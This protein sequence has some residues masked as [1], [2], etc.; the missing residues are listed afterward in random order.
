M[1]R[2]AIILFFT[3]L[4]V[5]GGEF[6]E[7]VAK[8]SHFAHQVNFPT[9]P[10]RIAA[11]GKEDIAE[12][13]KAVRLIM[14]PKTKAL[15]EDFIAHKKAHGSCIEKAIYQEMNVDGCIA[16]LI[17][18]RPLAF[19]T[20]EDHYLLRDGK[21]EG[22]GG[23]EAIG[24]DD[25]TY[26]LILRDYISYDEMQLGALIGI[27]VPT[28]FINDGDRYNRAVPGKAG[29][30]EP[31]GI[32]TALVGA[33][34]EKPGLMEWQHM[35]V[36]KDSAATSPLLHLWE[37]F[38]GYTFATYQEAEDD[39][40]GRFIPFKH[41]FFDSAVYKK[42]LQYVIEPFLQDAN[43][44]A[45]TANKKAYVR[46][47]GIG[48][49]VWKIIDKQTDLMLQVYKELLENNSFSHISDID[50]S[51]FKA[52]LPQENINGIALHFTQHNP[53]R[54][55]E[56]ND[57]GKL[58]VACYAWDSNAYP[59]NEYWLSDI[60]ASGDPA[61]ACCSTITELQNPLINRFI[62]SESGA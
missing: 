5:W 48:L 31:Q 54:I 57:A 32:Y 18:K 33:R 22:S 6:K 28:Y 39:T 19:L 1:F 11:I 14:H 25:E 46:V 27:S 53:A 42:R 37:Q 30:F 56:G 21:T 47:V 26:P 29:T 55:L 61:A 8:S 45:Q 58:L 23:F 15:I 59:G 44:R 50:F 9:Q 13:A 52:R 41:G 4:F 62:R 2:Y 34:F 20:A 16:R 3:P 35:V 49:G 40:T 36:T 12:Q 43:D 38:Y 24:T 60:T 51:H 17:E 10:N 7:L